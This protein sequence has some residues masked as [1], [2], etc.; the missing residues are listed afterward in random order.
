MDRHFAL[1]MTGSEMREAACRLQHGKQA[2]WDFVYRR[3]VKSGSAGLAAPGR[4][5]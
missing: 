4:A 3:Y 1:A 2:E 5:S